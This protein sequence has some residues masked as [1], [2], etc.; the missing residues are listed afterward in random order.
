MNRAVRS[1]LPF[2]QLLCRSSAKQRK[3]LVETITN[4][5]LRVLC[6]IALNVYRGTIPVR[7]QYVRKLRPY[8]TIL[9]TIIDRRV[10]KKLKIAVL[11]KN[12]R[13][14]PWILKPFL[15]AFNGSGTSIN[16]QAK[17]RSLDKT[18]TEN[19][20]NSYKQTQSESKDL[21]ETSTQNEFWNMLQ[22]T[23]PIKL[24]KKAKGLLKFL[25]NNGKDHLKWNDAGQLIYKDKSVEGSNVS[26]LVKDALTKNTTNN[27]IGYREFYSGLRDINIPTSLIL[28]DKRKILLSGKDI[29][30]GKGYVIKRKTNGAPPGFEPLKKKSKN[31]MIKWIKF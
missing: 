27:P 6:E 31:T 7:P 9:N 1:H 24:Q 5:Q 19:T 15:F 30:E 17:I 8:K 22:Y 10:R 4:D 21:N 25:L 12:R 26:D 29:Q 28:N 23:I 18:K 13:V 14:L 20:P 16:T 11:L 3:V 2:L